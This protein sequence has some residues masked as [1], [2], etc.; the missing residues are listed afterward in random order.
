M[1]LSRLRLLEAR[2]YQHCRQ[3]VN[4]VESIVVVE[5]TREK[6]GLVICTSTD[7]L[8][9]RL[10]ILTFLLQ[11]DN[12]I[13]AINV[14]PCWDINSI[15][16]IER[17]IIRGSIVDCEMS[18]ERQALQHLVQV[19]IDTRIKLELTTSKFTT[20]CRIDISKNIR[21]VCLSTSKEVFAIYQ[22]RNAH[23]VPSSLSIW[24][25]H[26]CGDKRSCILWKI[27][28]PSRSS[29]PVITLCRMRIIEGCT[30]VDPSL[31]FI[32]NVYIHIT[33]NAEALGIIILS[34]TKLEIIALAIIV[35]IAI[36]VSSLTTTADFCSSLITAVHLSEIIRRIEIEIRITIRVQTCSMIIDILSR[37]KLRQTII[38]TSLVIES[39][40]LC[41]AKILRIRLCYIQTCISLHL[42]LQA[43]IMTTLSGYD[44]STLGSL[45]TIEHHSLR[46]LEER[47]LCNLTWLNVVSFTRH[48]IYQ[49]EITSVVGIHTPERIAIPTT[50]ITLHIVETISMVVL[51]HQILYIDYRHTAQ[52]VIL[53]YLSVSHLNHL[54]VCT[55]CVGFACLC[56]L[57]IDT[58][59]SQ[60]HET[61]YKK[62]III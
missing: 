11:C 18:L 13:L 45:A 41:T 27:R 56:S 8:V 39:H 51:L 7:V 38:T 43:V 60:S 52:D 14:S 59:R 55:G 28:T 40:I 61:C 62:L 36:E 17:S 29:F 19:D 3:I 34:L 53:G 6:H 20:S 16:I 24:G 48:T 1:I 57:G 9:A 21:G 30:G 4:L 37:I 15:A 10:F 2:S 58:K 54:L 33:T 32:S 42:D 47:Y 12:H 31:N 49:D 25:N 35:D 5:L 23:Q 46:T 22:L 26:I 50:Y 44:Y